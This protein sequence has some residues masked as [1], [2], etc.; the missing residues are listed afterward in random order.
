MLS[1]VKQD[2]VT[3]VHFLIGWALWLQCY[4]MLGD[5]TFQFE[6]GK[7]QIYC[8]NVVIISERKTVSHEVIKCNVG[9]IIYVKSVERT[10]RESWE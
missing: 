10:Y 8:E 1:K 9:I 3:R 7:I 2:A 5:D 4:L 6:D